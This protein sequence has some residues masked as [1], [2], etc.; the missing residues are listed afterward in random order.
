MYKVPFSGLALSRI[1]SFL[2]PGKMNKAV[3][4]FCCMSGSIFCQIKSIGAIP[5][6]ALVVVS[7][8]GAFFITIE[9]LAPVI[10]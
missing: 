8:S 2:F 3:A 5:E 6:V 1:A 7:D 4:Y 9:W 10:V